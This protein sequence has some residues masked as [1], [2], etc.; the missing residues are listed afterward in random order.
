MSVCRGWLPVWAVCGLCLGHVAGQVPE[1][2]EAFVRVIVPTED[3]KLEIQGALTQQKGF[4][5]LFK[6]TTLVPGKKYFYDAKA[7]WTVD[8]KTMTREKSI[9]VMAGGTFELDMTVDDKPKHTKPKN[10]KP[11]PTVEPKRIIS[12][13]PPKPKDTKPVDTKPKE[14]K[15]V[16][17]PKPVEPPKPLPPSKLDAPTVSSPEPVVKKMLELAKVK[18]GDV[19]YDLGSGDGRIVIAAV[20]DFK[21]SKAVGIDIDPYQVFI[22]Q[23]RVKKENL[24]DKVTIR[25]FDIKKLTEKDLAEAT[26][27]TLY[28][29]P[30]TNEALKPILEK[31]KPG[32]RIV[33]HDY[34]IFGWNED[35]RAELQVDGLDHT[36]YLYTVK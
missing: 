14:P 9:L 7:T 15:P 24:S 21:V 17:P 30:K 26:V 35:G 34:D 2:N 20:K 33:S 6:S 36:V 8:G 4:K 32:T 18:P 31:L 25:Q 27:I 3:T 28:L 13:P 5:R 22:A 11:M 16:D 29:L 12:A 19:V 10:S 1:N 23:Q